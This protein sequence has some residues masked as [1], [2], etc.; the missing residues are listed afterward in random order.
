MDVKVDIN[1]TIEEYAKRP[2]WDEY[3]IKIMNDIGE[4]ATCDRGKSGC[5][6]TR[7]NRILTTGYVGAPRGFAHCDE[8]GHLMKKVI[9]D[10]G[11]I[12]EHCRRTIHSEINAILQAAM[13]GVAIAGATIYCSM[14]PCR[15]CAMA[16]IQCGILRVVA[17]YDYH[18]GAESKQMFADAGIEFVCMFEGAY[19]Y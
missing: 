11:G 8:V 13:N 16:I 9:Q 7:D 6:I 12:K 18:A 17:E 14:V 10:D 1:Y 5:V 15:D 19:K 2:S 4:R 3:F